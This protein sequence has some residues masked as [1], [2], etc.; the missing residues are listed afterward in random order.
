MGNN[1]M[2]EEPVETFEDLMGGDNN[3]NNQNINEDEALYGDEDML[4]NDDNMA[5]G[6]EGIAVQDYG[7]DNDEGYFY[8]K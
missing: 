5:G 4:L 3:N 6:D 2:V 7:G 8:N 1:H